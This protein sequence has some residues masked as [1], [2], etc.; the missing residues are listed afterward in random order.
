VTFTIFPA[1]SLTVVAAA[2]TMSRMMS[3]ASCASLRN[4]DIT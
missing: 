4:F 3:T 1:R 2:V